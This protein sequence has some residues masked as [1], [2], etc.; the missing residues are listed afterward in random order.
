MRVDLILLA[1]MLHLPEDIH[2]IRAETGEGKIYLALEAFA[3]GTYPSPQ[4]AAVYSSH[5]VKDGKYCTRLIGW[6]PIEPEL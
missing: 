2:I 6:V 5:W 1:E 3:D 4:S